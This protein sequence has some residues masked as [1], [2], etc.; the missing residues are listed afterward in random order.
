MRETLNQFIQLMN[1]TPQHERKFMTL[2]DTD[3]DVQY[4]GDEVLDKAN[5]I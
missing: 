1:L 3:E 4:F 2:F 5:D